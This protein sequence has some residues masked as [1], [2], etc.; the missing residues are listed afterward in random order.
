[1][2]QAILRGC[3][4][5]YEENLTYNQLMRIFAQNFYRQQIKWGI[6][7]H[8]VSCTLQLENF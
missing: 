5:F 7:K 3:L 4:F 6:I 8:R 2:K 1:M